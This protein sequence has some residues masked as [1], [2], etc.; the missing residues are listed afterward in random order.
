ML[1]PIT[2]EFLVSTSI[3]KTKKFEGKN[4]SKNWRNRFV[5]FS[6]QL[7]Q[8]M[9]IKMPERKKNFDLYQKKI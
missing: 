3:F 9:E 2:Y 7:F 5:F 8:K 6:L 1:F 4:M